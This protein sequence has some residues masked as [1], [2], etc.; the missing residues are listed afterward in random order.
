MR[1]KLV[2][3]AQTILRSLTLGNCTRSGT[4]PKNRDNGYSWTALRGMAWQDTGTHIRSSLP[5][6]WIMHA[7]YIE[8]ESRLKRHGG[9]GARSSARESYRNTGLT[10]SLGKARSGTHR[11]LWKG[12]KKKE[13]E[14]ERERERDAEV[15]ECRG[16]G[17]CGTRFIGARLL[18]QRTRKVDFIK[19]I[20]GSI[21]LAWANKS[22]GNGVLIKPDSGEQEQAAWEQPTKG[23]NIQHTQGGG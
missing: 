20:Y 19:R 23:L 17:S 6:A 4:G 16:P 9:V 10:I 2:R 13:R 7:A 22:S 12:A 21:V 5:V 3:C 1:G 18:R 14:R 15:S 11:S 8:A